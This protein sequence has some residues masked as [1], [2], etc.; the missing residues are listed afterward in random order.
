MKKRIGLQRALTL[1]GTV[2]AILGARVFLRVS[3]DSWMEGFV[4][5]GG[6]LFILL[7]FAIRIVARGVKEDESQSGGKLVVTGLY[8]F[9]R[10]PMYLGTLCIGIGVGMSLLQWWVTGIFL[11]AYLAIYIPQV[12]REEKLLRNVFGEEY[13]RYLLSTPRIL[14]AYRRWGSFLGKLWPRKGKWVRREFLSL[15]LV[16]SVVLAIQMFIEFKASANIEFWEEP[17][18]FFGVL[19]AFFVI[20]MIFAREEE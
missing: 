3:T 20:L 17:L 15:F 6:M 5:I 12:M 13:S 14:P 2:T 18:E 11:T 1:V 16:C 7:G 10:N 9:T 8:A 4:E 19:G